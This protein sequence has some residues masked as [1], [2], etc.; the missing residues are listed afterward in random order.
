MMFHS[1]SSL[2]G[3]PRFPA[4]IT[5]ITTYKEGPIFFLFESVDLDGP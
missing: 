1:L 5:A 3:L 4:S 2:T